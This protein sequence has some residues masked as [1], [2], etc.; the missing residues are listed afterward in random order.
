MQQQKKKLIEVALP[1]EAINKELAR[2]KSIRHGH[3]STLHLWWARR[4]LAAC[5]AVLFAQLV[6]DPSSHPDR[7]PKEEDQDRERLRL[8]N[9]IE[10]LVKWEN[11]N[12][13]E[14]LEEAR[15]EIRKSTGG[16]PP[17]VL[18]P[19]AGGG[20]IPL[21]AQR[22][23]L[24]AH[25]SDLNPVA[26]LINKALI[27][28]P[29]KF[30]GQLPVHPG[31]ETERD[32]SEWKGAWGL[33]EGVRYYGKWMRDE[34]EKRIGH[35]YP[36]VKLP[37]EQGGGE[38]TVIAWLWART[39]AS[40]NPACKGAHVPLVRSFWL[41]KKKGKEAWVEPL[42]DRERNTY[43]FE[44]RM[45]KGNPRDGTVNRR[46][47]TC[48]LSGV[49]MPFNY[50]R[51]EGKAGR[52]KFR[53]MAIVAEGSNGRVYLPPTE[54]HEEIARRAIPDW[55]PEAD[56]P[57]N[58]RDFKTPNYGMNTFADLFTPRQLVAL[59]T[60]SDLVGEAREQV[61]RDATAFGL[62][63][64]GVSL[65]DGGT[66]AA[67]YAD[68][69]ATYLAF[70]VDRVAD[71]G[72]TICSWDTGYVKVRN[73]FG[74][75]AIP[76]TWDF[77]ESNP[78]SNSTGN[79]NGAVHWIV[80]VVRETPCCTR[81][82]VKQADSTAPIRRIDQPIISTDPPYYDNIGY[83]DLSDFFYVWLRRSLQGIYPDLFSTMLVP[84]SEELVATPYRFD[85]DKK[86][87]QSF[88]ENG[89]RQAFTRMRETAHPE[90]P[91]TVYYAFKQAEAA[92]A[93]GKEGEQAVASTGWETMLEGLIRSGFSITGT[94]P[95]R[96]ELGNRMVA[97]G[98]NALASSIVLV[99]R[100][101]P[102]DTRPITRRD[103]LRALKRELPDALRDLQ[104]GNIA[105]VDMAQAAIGP[106][107]AV[108]SRYGKVIESDGTAMRVRTALALINQ[109][110]DEFLAEQEGEFDSDTRWALSWFEQHGME[111]GPYGEAE[112]LS[113]ARNTS[114]EGLVEA[115]ILEAKSGK[116]RLLKREEL[117]EDWN[118][119]EDD[120]VTVWEAVQYLIRALET[121][122]ETGAATLFRQLGETG[123]AARDLAY[124]LYTLCERKG[125]AQEALAYNGLVT[126]WPHI[127][128]LATREEIA[129]PGQDSLNFNS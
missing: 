35:L 37:E 99:C 123:E 100:P 52:M 128:D 72:S 120:R 18:D 17:P 122:G 32:L 127:T 9:I 89:L 68:A 22:L 47:G 5:R 92:A 78:M 57:V 41:S 103:F 1:L 113:T 24:E 21:E 87:A 70:A 129:P 34:A 106:G 33:A 10:K 26:V 83:A 14:V 91:L 60:F 27:E 51:T 94:W 107:M 126:S 96:T 124:R 38:A 105:P 85:G 79:F 76:M 29:P 20:S 62:S 43:R 8:F 46:G 88:F 117:L 71:R 42:V 3:P 48:L 81:G 112:T 114:V 6:D 45:G 55:K 58:P 30:A 104:Q 49:P 77:A 12:D 54:E 2:E 4:P 25:A 80:E 108:F 98:T 64:D 53:L 50:I 116:V 69:V 11:I 75:Q 28:I 40:P 125:W 115:G 39:V 118:P 82:S 74:R 63:D 61:R 13:E 102:E 101:R 23:G 19:F 59:N 97:S 73:T 65:K 31:Q 67:A 93:S 86:K 66:G 110:L 111:R 7:F 36:K 109:T 56:L 84:K 121:D 95:M 90:F 16:N 119:N 15:E 44:V